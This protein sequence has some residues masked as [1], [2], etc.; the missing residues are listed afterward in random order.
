MSF[1]T[2]EKRNGV[3]I[4][5]LNQTDSP[6]NKVSLEVIEEF[7]G[8]FKQLNSDAEVKACVLISKK[9]DFI[10]GADIDMFKKVKKKGDFEPF[11]RRG[12]VALNDLAASQKPVVAAI[13]G[14]CLGAGTEIALACHARIASDHRS[15]HLALPEIMLGL[16][17][18]GGG[19]QRLPRLIGIQ[20]SL[21]MLLTGKKIY[22][23]KAVKMN[24]VD[25]LTTQ[26]SLLQGAVDFALELTNKPIVRTDKRTFVEKLLE[27]NS[28]TRGIVYKKAKEMVMRKTLGNYP[29][30]FKILECVEAGMEGGMQKG[31]DAEAVKFEEL[32]LTEV[33]R[34]LINIFF[35]MT[36]KK[37]NPYA[38]ELVREVET[39][40]M[41][42]AGFMGAGIAEVSI[43][44]GIDVL[45]KDIKEE[46]I[47]TA[48][49]GIWKSYARKIARKTMSEPEA[50]ELINRV[51]S[52]L[53]Y[54]GFD[55]AEVVIEAVFEEVKLKQR[56]VADVEAA[57][58]NNAIFASNT[59]ALPISS[60][61]E[62]AARPEQII[63]MH[64]FSPVPKMPL[65]EIVKTPKT[66]D[67]VTATCYELGVRQGKTN[68][69]VNDGPG[70]YT[71]RILAPYFNEALLM[72]QEGCDAG[73][74]DKAMKKYGFPVGPVTLLDEVGLDVGAHVM[75]G[76]LI[77][78]Y[79]QRKGAKTNDAVKK[80]FEAGR[81]G[82]KNKQG[83]YKYDESGK[84]QGVDESAYQFFGNPTRKAFTDE[85]IQNRLGFAMI[86]ECM[87][88]L[89]ENIIENPLDG[90]VGAI[91]GLGFPPFKGGPFRYIDFLGA[92][93][94]LALQES[95]VKEAGERFTPTQLLRDKAAKGERFY[96]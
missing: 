53:D 69:V 38:K 19:T 78:Y 59:S 40:G 91:F 42:G 75:S 88:C 76:E 30:P 93:N 28:L 35:A 66:A 85:Q 36:D 81:M 72:I 44:D 8:I 62:K 55:K 68:I 51:H 84:K 27:S 90:D 57:I 48:K 58:S 29:A 60:I 95:L 94:A 80:M 63:G 25:R 54:S 18:G 5:W 39:L 82:K 49:Q 6:I 86:H 92:E 52:K 96:A 73:L 9:K 37:K 13:H 11:T 16:L 2:I 77:E 21:D 64:Y 50:Q 87:L 31:L 56:I 20:R 43:A 3:A 70:F 10:A 46:T 65:L 34:Q 15:T 41:V 4:I 7:D 33:S 71:T 45:L 14:A 23:S 79:K 32:I 89:E 74:I 67:W 22:A 1:A 17:P 12:H 83:F 26:E 24:L 61:A 47:A